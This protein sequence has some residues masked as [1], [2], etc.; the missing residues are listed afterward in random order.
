M[1]VGN[2]NSSNIFD[3]LMEYDRKKTK[4]K[5]K[6]KDGK[7]YHCKLICFAEDE[8]DWAYCIETLENPSRGFVLECNFIETIETISLNEQNAD[9]EYS[10]AENI[11][12]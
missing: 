4:L 7:I 6:T 9:N 2:M 3:I 5:I 1:N 12:G 8:E 11:A 10:V